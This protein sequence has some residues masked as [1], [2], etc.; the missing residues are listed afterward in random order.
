MELTN[1]LKKTVRSLDSA[2][3]R[4]ESVLF[5]AQGTKC[6]LDTLSHFKVYTLIATR[7]WIEEHR[8][9]LPAGI[10]TT[11]AR[12][13]DLQAVTTLSSTPDVIAVYHQPGVVGHRPSAT[14][15]SIALDCLQD[16]GNMGTIIRLASWMGID[17]IYCSRDCVDIYSPK[18]IQSTMGAIARVNVIY[19]D[20]P[21]TLGEAA[22]D[23][24]SIYGT[25]LE[26]TDIYTAPLNHAGILVMGNEGR[27]IRPE[28]AATVTD[29]LFIPPYPADAHPQDSLNV[30]VATAI[31]V[32]EFRRRN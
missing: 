30:A 11:S 8:D 22:R 32:A 5:M 3:G 20:L 27:G 25:F 12:R 14:R 15:L 6:V 23:G 13:A 28:V 21:L 17:D 2:K 31:A 9:R 4:R 24:I 19:C 7:E 10:D 18:V 29:K 16:P 1:A 26:G